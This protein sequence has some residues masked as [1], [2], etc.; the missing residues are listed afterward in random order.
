MNHPFD[1]PAM[2]PQLPLALDW[3][4]GLEFELFEPGANAEAVAAV[5]A[6]GAP[7]A[8][9]VCLHGVSG[10]GKTHLLQAQCGR[11][12]RGGG[13]AVY[14]PLAQFRQQSPDL[15][16]GLETVDLVAVDDGDCLRDQPA[17]QEAI[18]HLY[19]R[20]RDAGGA[21]L[22]AGRTRPDRLPEL[23]PDLSSRLRWGLVFRLQPLDDGAALAALQRR[24][25][26]RGLA[27]PEEVGRYLL[28]RYPRGTARLFALLD[29]LDS[30]SL[31]A[32]RRLTIPFIRQVLEAD[33]REPGSGA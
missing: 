10:V 15:C 18:F 21:F 7:G 1:T 2:S 25:G 28:A 20:V 16:D 29:T 22:F 3:D 23:L 8:L 9:P 24:A 6:L 14:L 31:Q 13:T 17:W 12:A 30:A 11:V 19:N 33:S 5:A 4:D 26:R 27:L 32:G